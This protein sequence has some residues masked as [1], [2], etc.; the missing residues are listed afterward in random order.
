MTFFNDTDIPDVGGEGR[1]YCSNDGTYD[2]LAKTGVKW[3]DG[4]IDG[5][6]AYSEKIN[7]INYVF[8]GLALAVGQ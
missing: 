5:K 1:Y 6:A 4:A 7:A 3:G 8:S 2:F